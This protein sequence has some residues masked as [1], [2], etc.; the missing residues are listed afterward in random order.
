MTRGRGRPSLLTETVLALA[1]THFALGPHGPT[2]LAVTLGISPRVVQQWLQQAE[3]LLEGADE[4]VE[5]LGEHEQLCLKL[6]QI[7]R[8]NSSTLAT[9]GI[10]AIQRNLA[11][12]DPDLATARWAVEMHFGQIGKVLK[13]GDDEGISSQGE[14]KMQP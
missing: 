9:L 4:D 6:L 5:K 1:E 11:G 2:S 8:K 14:Q 7:R 12:P 3:L 13:G 10:R